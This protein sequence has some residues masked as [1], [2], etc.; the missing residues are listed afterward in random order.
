MTLVIERVLGEI[1]ACQLQCVDDTDQIDG[2]DLELRLG[3]LFG[4]CIT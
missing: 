2:K 3:W 4:I 1:V